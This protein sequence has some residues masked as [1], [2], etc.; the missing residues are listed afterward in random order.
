MGREPTRRRYLRDGRAPVRV[1]LADDSAIVRDG[2]ARV[3]G[4]VGFEICGSAQ[5]ADELLRL[6]EHERPDAVIVDIR[7]PPSHTDEGIVAATEIRNRFPEVGV[8]VLSQHVETEYA[9][10]LLQDRRGR[11]GYL[12]QDRVTRI[13]ELTEAIARIVRGEI[14]V[15]P[16]LVHRLM[17]RN[18][19]P[20]RELTPREREV[21]A[22]MAEGFTD[23]G[24]AARLWVTQKTVETHAVHI[25]RKLDLPEGASY[26][27]RVHA[28][29]AYLRA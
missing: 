15:D 17:S 25:F 28:V 9:L 20:V 19:S 4:D 8:L 10:R 11:C 24:I 5:D 13:G 2:L 26:N 12:L 27:R 18:A 3:L 23:R 6:V 21:L 29:L 22:L 16:E 7:M 1:A 14:V